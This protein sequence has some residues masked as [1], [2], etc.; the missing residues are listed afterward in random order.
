MVRGYVQKRNLLRGLVLYAQ[1]HP[2]PAFRRRAESLSAETFRQIG[3]LLA[4]RPGA[5]RHDDPAAAVE[6]AFASV[7]HLLRATLFPEHK[8]RLPFA[9]SASRL[10]EELSRMVLRYL[11]IE[12]AGAG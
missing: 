10:A 4:S 2:D 9:G 7:G 8:A 11:G 3:A 12:D 6:L 5:I 1:T